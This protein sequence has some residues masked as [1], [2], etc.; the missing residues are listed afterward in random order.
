MLDGGGVFA[1]G[2][3]FLLVS[4]VLISFKCAESSQR[5]KIYIIDKIWHFKMKLP[6]WLCLLLL[7]SQSLRMFKKSRDNKV[8]RGSL[9]EAGPQMWASVWSS[10]F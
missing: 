6:G 5:A 10:L 7:C 3:H 9:M 4:T 2:L 8:V 1:P